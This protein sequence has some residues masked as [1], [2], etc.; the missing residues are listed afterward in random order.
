MATRLKAQAAETVALL[1]RDEVRDDGGLL[2]AHPDL[3]ER[4]LV[5]L[6]G[7]VHADE[8]L[9]GDL[10]GDA[11]RQGPVVLAGGEGVDELPRGRDNGVLR[12]RQT[13]PAHCFPPVGRGRLYFDRLRLGRRTLSSSSRT[14]PRAT[15]RAKQRPRCISELQPLLRP[16]GFEPATSGLGNRCSILLSYGRRALWN[17]DLQLFTKPDL[18]GSCLHFV[19][20]LP[21]FVG[22]AKVNRQNHRYNLLY[23]ET[24]GMS[25]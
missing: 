18:S 17:K 23:E 24:L 11:Q 21:G 2:G 19:T 14:E 20:S 10:A 6:E 3:G 9:L 15:I 22:P 16:A 8:A 7:V 12:L 4:R 5:P 1:G 25:T 13:R